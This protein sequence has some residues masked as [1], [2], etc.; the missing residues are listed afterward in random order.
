MGR[1]GRNKNRKPKQQVVRQE[2]SQNPDE[3]IRKMPRKRL[4]I[5]IVHGIGTASR[6]RWFEKSVKPLA[7]SF[8]RSLTM[9]W[10]QETCDSIGCRNRQDG[11]NHTHL[12]TD[13]GTV[14]AEL[15]AVYWSDAVSIP[16]W[17]QS[18]KWSA[19]TAVV[20]LLT[21]IVAACLKAI[22]PTSEQ[23]NGKSPKEITAGGPNFKEL[24]AWFVRFTALSL[25]S[26][27]IIVLTILG[28][29][30]M[31]P[32]PRKRKKHLLDAMAWTAA[33]ESRKAIRENVIEQIRADNHEH[34][35]LIGH[36][37]GGAILSDIVNEWTEKSSP[38]LM[39]LGSGQV[40]LSTARLVDTR[41]KVVGAIVYISL[42][43][44]YGIAAIAVILPLVSV[45]LNFLGIIAG[46]GIALASV[47]WAIAND[48]ELGFLLLGQFA[49]SQMGLLPALTRS[50]LSIPI[51]PVAVVAVMFGAL[52]L[53]AG[54]VFRKQINEIIVAM[55]DSQVKAA[56]VDISAH[57]DYV[58]SPMSV[59]G[60]PK[61]FLRIPMRGIFP[62]DHTSYFQ[63]RHLA[64]RPIVE[65][66][67]E[68]VE[69]KYPESKPGARLND[70]RCEYSA[71]LHAIGWA[72]ALAGVILTFLTSSSIRPESFVLVVGVLVFGVAV[73]ILLYVLATWLLLRDSSAR[74]LGHLTED[75]KSRNRSRSRSTGIVLLVVG[76]FAFGIQDANSPHISVL[77]VAFVASAVMT[78]SGKVLAAPL[79]SI[80]F[81]AFGIAWL[82]TWSAVGIVVGVAMIFA[83]F[84]VVVRAIRR[85]QAV[86]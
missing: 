53:L 84:I 63:S 51:A 73:A 52:L 68:L 39:T 12:T 85:T 59:M 19:K 32:L 46:S 22:C 27:P 16:R 83:A 62:L 67:E 30:V 74:S 34:T 86:E 64:L 47:V 9:S 69:S 58:S 18:V 31:A 5:P 14:E 55:K 10:T 23:A 77:A 37:Q 61:R 38:I 29:I 81:L 15:R 2:K 80:V 79:G 35:I 28:A 65:A 20:I 7:E 17:F 78:F 48:L 8:T 75:W 54:A 40:I 49:D 56:G 42:L 66:A 60:N 76:L 44:L 3:P 57:Q 41:K 26:V 13:N 72:I 33:P 70:G 71:R 24:L 43:V 4:L 45:L 11:E 21:H 82:H 36:S 1:S 6:S 50:V 25:V